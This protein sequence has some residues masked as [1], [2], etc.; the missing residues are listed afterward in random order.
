MN[1]G[2]Y[3]F[4]QATSVATPVVAEAGVPFVVGLAP[5]HTAEKS[6]KAGIPVLCTSWDEAVER[7]GYSDDWEKYTIC[8]FMYSHF[9]LFGCQ[10]VVFCNILDPDTMSV[11]VD[12]REYTVLDHKVLLP[13]SAK[14]DDTLRVEI[15]GPE[16]DGIS[17]IETLVKG[18]D[19][20]TY[21]DGEYLV[22]ELL[23][24]SEYYGVSALQ[25]TYYSVDAARVSNADIAA[26]IEGMELCMTRL[27]IVP[28]LICVPG[29]SH[30]TTIAAL[31]ATK[32][33]SINGLFSAKALIDLDCG[34]NGVRIY[35][36]AYAAKQDG[37]FTD[38]NEILCWP[39][40]QLG[41]YRFHLSTQLAGLMAQVD[42][43]NGGVP[44]ESPS[45]KNLQCDSLCLAD[46]TEVNLTFTQANVLNGYGLVTALNFMNGWVAWGNNTACYPAN[47][48]VK[49]YHIPISR[50]FDWVGNTMVRTFWSRLDQPMN[51]RLIDTILDTANIWLSGLVGSGYLLGARVEML[52]DEN[53]LTNLMQGIVKL[54]IYMTPPSAAQEIDF[55]LEYDV[56]Y[57]QAALS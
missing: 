36:D 17:E 8:E 21:Y 49:D 11:K 50:M 1:H 32:A 14:S 29:Y 51:R 20:D 3:V 30:I 4:E 55:V 56:S 46:G 53:P 48:D 13:L 31:M 23:A 10:P 25:I 57:V 38:E 41:E 52:D 2:V 42:T 43:N 28:D 7:L 19:Y 18:T 16:E 15:E 45:N 24:D 35:S 9:K 37:N 33:A 44:Y 34:T 5:V 39:M 12:P 22:I 40:V 26:G 27:G 47:T 6:E 54:H